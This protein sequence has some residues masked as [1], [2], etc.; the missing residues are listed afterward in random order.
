MRNIRYIYEDNDILVCHKPAGVATE[1]AKSYTM[2]LVSAARNYLSRKNG[3]SKKPP[4]VATVH[5][6]DQPVEGV[7]V[8]AK[9]KKAAGDISDQIKNRSTGKYYYALCYGTVPND[10]G[11]LVD[12]LIRKEDGLAAVVSKAEKD[13]LKDLVITRENGEKIRTVAGDVKKAALEYE[14]VKRTENTTLLRIRLLTGRFHQI[15][16]Q[17]SHYGYP[18]LG[19]KNY[20]SAESVRFSEEN[21]I[22]DICLVSYKFELKHPSTGEKMCFEIN[23]DNGQI[24]NMI[25]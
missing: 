20:G 6:L 25:S 24:K 9:T 14:V 22:S 3:K 15:R 19:E 5:R 1:G 12:Y 4:Y 13:S 7:V 23:P 18:I 10:G 17:L 11:K 16:V 8:L 21:G 2:D